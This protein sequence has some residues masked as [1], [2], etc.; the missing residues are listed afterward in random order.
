MNPAL[1]GKSSGI[2]HAHQS[3]KTQY[4]IQRTRQTRASNGS[5]VK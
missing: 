5:V 2:P 4:H 1:N 3:N